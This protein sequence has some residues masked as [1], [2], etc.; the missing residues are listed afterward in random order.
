MSLCRK[1]R[2][3]TARGGTCGSSRR[4]GNESPCFRLRFHY[5]RRNRHVSNLDLSRNQVRSD[6]HLQLVG[7]EQEHPC[8]VFSCC[9]RQVFAILTM[10]SS[11]YQR[12]K[13]ESS[14]G[15]NDLG[16]QWIRNCVP[17][18]TSRRSQ[19]QWHGRDGSGG[20]EATVQNSS[21]L[22]RTPCR[23]GWRYCRLGQIISKLWIA[24]DGTTS[25]SD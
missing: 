18:T 21:Y 16:M 24:R 13:Y 8:S 4:N 19:S 17:R 9:T 1:T 14:A 11:V 2:R 23:I 6:R 25:D 12:T 10:G 7:N 5:S 20:N 15:C 22:C 3:R